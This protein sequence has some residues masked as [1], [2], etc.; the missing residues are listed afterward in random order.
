[1]NKWQEKFIDWIKKMIEN[2]KNDND[3]RI[4]ISLKDNYINIVWIGGWKCDIRTDLDWWEESYIVSTEDVN[5][6]MECVKARLWKKAIYNV[7]C[8]DWCIY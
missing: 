5:E 3:M 1:M 8:Y 2:N 4:D 6:I 7:D